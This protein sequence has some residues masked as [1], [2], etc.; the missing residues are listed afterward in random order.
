[1]GLFSKS[2][3]DIELE[4][5]NAREKELLERLILFP[6]SVEEYSTFR[7]YNVEVVDT[8]RRDKGVSYDDH[9]DRSLIASLIYKKGVEAL[10]N[11]S[12]KAWGDQWSTN[13]YLYG[14]P[15][16]KQ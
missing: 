6:G 14:L 1:M 10:V 3:Q 12:F 13:T 11:I 16:R 5:K 9:S 2:D 15:V 8:E 7:G 4:R